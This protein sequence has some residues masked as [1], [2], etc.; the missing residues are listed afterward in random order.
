MHR[1]CD[2][3]ISWVVDEPAGRSSHSRHLTNAGHFLLPRRA[4]SRPA[5]EHVL[6]LR[7]SFLGDAAAAGGDEDKDEQAD[8]QHGGPVP[9]VRLLLLGLGVLPAEA[10]HVAAERFR[11]LGL[12]GRGGVDV[13]EKTVGQALLPRH[14]RVVSN[15]NGAIIRRYLGEGLV[16]SLQDNRGR[17]CVVAQLAAVHV[18][19]ELALQLLSIPAEVRPAFAFATLLHR[20]V[21]VAYQVHVQLL[22]VAR[23]LGARLEGVKVRLAVG[24]GHPVPVALAVLVPE[25][26]GALAVPVLA[27]RVQRAATVAPVLEIVVVVVR[28][29]VVS[30][31][32]PVH[33]GE[34]PVLL[35]PV[36]HGGSSDPN[37]HTHGSTAQEPGSN[38]Q[39]NAL[40]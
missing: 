36:V 39:T 35:I 5:R 29:A 32:V 7:E 17:L 20:H 12:L 2:G 38:P 8:D 10:V 30:A 4:G 21:G 11:D 37:P 9:A 3:L 26:V 23:L 14:R 28:V 6:H 40:S 1:G 19:V 25:P 22:A 16:R 18:H 31:R 33:V 34:H 13:A 24:C 15:L 27:A